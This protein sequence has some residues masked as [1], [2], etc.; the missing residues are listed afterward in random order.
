MSKAGSRSSRA[1]N[2]VRVYRKTESGLKE[3]RTRAHRLGHWMRF[4]LVMVNGRRSE[5]ELSTLMGSSGPD[6]LRELLE[7][8]LIEPVT[9]GLTEPPTTI[10][11]DTPP[12][13][14]LPMA[15][16]QARALVWIAEEFGSKGAPLTRRVMR[17]Q[18]PDDLHHALVLTER[19]MRRAQGRD[20][21]HAFQRDVGLRPTEE[22]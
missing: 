17:A 2:A 22:H 8:G 3:M 10:Q 19:F 20:R 16:A 11:G 13:L 6:T 7:L 1:E 14:F 21:A 12:F 18:T 4:A 5:A 9:T 15:L